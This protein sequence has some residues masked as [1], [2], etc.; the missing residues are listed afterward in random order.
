MPRK[1]SGRAPLARLLR[2][3]F[4]MQSNRFPNSRTL[5]EYLGVGRRTIFRDFLA[6]EEAGVQIEYFPDRLGYGLVG[7][8]NSPTSVPLVET[9]VA[10]L[11]VLTELWG[12]RD[13]LG[14]IRTAREGLVKVVGGLPHDARDRVHALSQPLECTI[15][16]RPRERR[17]IYDGLL[18]AL[19]TRVQVGVEYQDPRDAA[20][21]ATRVSP[22]RIVLAQTMW[23]LIGRS[24]FHR[25]VSLFRLP[26]IRGLVKTDE[27]YTIPPRFDMTPFLAGV[28]VGDPSASSQEVWLRFSRLVAPEILDVTWH[29]TQLVTCLDDGR[30]ELRFTSSS[31]DELVR[32]VLGFGDQVE[33]LSPHAFRH[34]VREVAHRVCRRHAPTPLIEGAPLQLTSDETAPHALST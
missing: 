10:S 15:Q 20:L 3:M 13:G 9:E 34:R 2:L 31:I 27:P 4:L 5:S 19:R 33:I 25:R 21:L 24:S 22:Y 18:D 12:G 17:S 32:W 28:W 8:A 7:G 11:I 6:L 14:L 26:Y 16:E 30:V 23:C 29:P 1:P